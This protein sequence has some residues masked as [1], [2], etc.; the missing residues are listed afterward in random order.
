MSTL[1]KAFINNDNK[2][3]KELLENGENP[4][5]QTDYRR[6]PLHYAVSNN[7]KEITIILLKY[8]L[9]KMIR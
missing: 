9:I 5:S 2:T 4:N 8:N 3:V 1:H 7:Y 6:T